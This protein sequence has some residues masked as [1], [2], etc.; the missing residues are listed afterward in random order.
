MTCWMPK[1]FKWPGPPGNLRLGCAATEQAERRA[2]SSSSFKPASDSKLTPR[3]AGPRRAVK[4]PPAPGRLTGCC[5]PSFIF[6]IRASGEAAAARAA[7]AHGM[8]AATVTGIASARAGPRRLHAPG[9]PGGQHRGRIMLPL[10]STPE[11]R[12]LAGVE[13]TTL[14]ARFK[15]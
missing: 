13:E 8:P 15:K 11:A 14:P 6:G 10:P 7:E 1:T 2:A 5:T 9:P 3:P 4:I 12:S